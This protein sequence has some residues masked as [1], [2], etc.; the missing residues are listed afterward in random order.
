LSAFDD[1]L[2]R[3][4]GLRRFIPA[5]AK[6]DEVARR[7]QAKAEEEKIKFEQI[8][9]LAPSGPQKRVFRA[10][11]AFAEPW[12]TSGV[13]GG[14]FFPQVT[15]GLTQSE[16]I[17]V[18]AKEAILQLVPQAIEGWDKAAIGQTLHLLGRLVEQVPCYRLRLSPQ[19]EQLPGVIAGGMDK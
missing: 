13:A 10:E 19:V 3:F 2:E 7:G 4:E 12:A 14:I 5:K 18:S 6:A 17:K 8:D 1:S 16:L 9:L 11:E 15:P